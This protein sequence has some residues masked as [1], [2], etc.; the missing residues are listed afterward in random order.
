MQRLRISNF[1]T[2]R[3]AAKTSHMPTSDLKEGNVYQNETA[4]D[5]LLTETEEVFEWREVFRGTRLLSPLRV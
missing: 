5:A 2:S 3:I 4:E 1:D